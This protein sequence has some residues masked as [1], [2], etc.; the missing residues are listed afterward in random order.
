MK[1]LK[2]VLKPLVAV[3]ATVTVITGALFSA[4]DARAE[5]KPIR[6]GLVSFLSGPA[7]GP[8]GVPAQVAA[9]ARAN[10]DA[11]DKGKMTKSPA[12]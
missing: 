6:I 5:D 2:L 11:A 3:L 7:A 1:I 8:F 12:H 9:E 4:P 10:A